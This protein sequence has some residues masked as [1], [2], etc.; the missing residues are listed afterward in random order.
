MLLA[1][2]FFL[3]WRILHT[4]T[5][6]R[7]RFDVLLA[8]GV[9]TIFLFHVFVNVGMTMGIMPVTGIPLPFISYG[10]SSLVLSVLSLSRTP[11]EHSGSL[12]RGGLEASEGV[13]PRQ[14]ALV[15]GADAGYT[16]AS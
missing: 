5:I 2:F 7:D 6:S 14:R 13:R 10:R 11:A 1:L 16:V 12:P 3:V 9:A 4:A 15:D 8:V